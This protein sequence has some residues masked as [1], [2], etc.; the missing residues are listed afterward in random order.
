MHISIQFKWKDIS[1]YN[2]NI[3]FRNFTYSS[4]IV[5]MPRCEGSMDASWRSRATWECGCLGGFGG[6]RPLWN[7]S[8][9]RWTCNQASIFFCQ[10]VCTSGC[11]MLFPLSRNRKVCQTYLKATPR[12]W[13]LKTPDRLPCEP[14][15]LPA[16]TQA[17]LICMICNEKSSIWNP[18]SCHFQPPFQED[19]WAKWEGEEQYPD[20]NGDPS[21]H[22]LFILDFGIFQQEVP[23]MPLNL[24]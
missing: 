8:S 13:K 10:P 16:L 11:F 21:L 17:Q 2:L 1:L 19:I 6:A 15:E 7:P 20:H 3:E 5:A 22:L 12:N 14:E 18:F 24:G 23:K 4:A 9:W